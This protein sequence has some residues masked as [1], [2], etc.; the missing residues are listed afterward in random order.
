[1]H[2]SVVIDNHDQLLAKQKQNALLA[3]VGRRGEKKNKE[4]GPEWR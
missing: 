4:I 3:S 2:G 1:L